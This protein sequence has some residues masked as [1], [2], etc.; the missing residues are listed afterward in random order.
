MAT[1]IPMAAAGL[2]APQGEETNFIHGKFAVLSMF[3]RKRRLPAISMISYF[4][5]GFRFLTLLGLSYPHRM[6]AVS[7]KT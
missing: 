2:P 6:R 3:F 7:T 1:A 4:R 5:E